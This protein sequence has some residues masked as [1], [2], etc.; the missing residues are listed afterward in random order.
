MNTYGSQVASPGEVR[1]WE[2]APSPYIRSLLVANAFPPV[3]GGIET[4]LYQIVTHMDGVRTLVYAPEVAGGAEFDR[5]TQVEIRRGRLNE[6]GLAGRAAR[7]LVTR[8]SYPGV[9]RSYQYLPETARLVQ[10]E[11]IQVVQIGHIYLAPLGYWIWR[12]FGIPYVVY[13]Y[14]QEVTEAHLPQSRWVTR[15]I[16]RRMLSAAAGIITNC[17]F[18]AQHVRRWGIGDDRIVKIR[19][20]VDHR[21]FTPG[22]AHLPAQ[23]R[24]AIAGKRVILTVGRLIPRKGHDVVI[25]ALARLRDRVPDAVYLVAGTGPCR[26]ELEAQAASLGLADRVIF[27]GYVP[28]SELVNLLRASDTFVMPSRSR[29]D[30]GDVEGLPLVYLQAAACSV[31]AIGGDTGGTREAILHE[32]TGLIVDPEDP[33]D[34]ADAIVRLLEGRAFARSLG[35]AARRRVEHEMNW[36]LGGRD[37]EALLARVRR[38]GPAGTPPKMGG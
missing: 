18:T 15:H 37:V 21:A 8:L 33:G 6:L 14:G 27:L 29:L 7:R 24:E 9:F 11:S 2:R 31:P 3:V 35:E 25:S 12:R 16:G 4:F 23:L 20:G 13:T 36:E 26:A 30:G 22:P 5:S 38:S 28:D 17:D 1:V 32:R 10:N 19:H 34:V